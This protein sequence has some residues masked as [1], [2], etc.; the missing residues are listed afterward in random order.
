M[1][2]KCRRDLPAAAGSFAGILGVAGV[3]LI[4]EK[5]GSFNPIFQLTAAMYVV[6]ALVW[7][8]WCQGTVVFE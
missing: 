6:G 3:G 1:N 8:L 2:L 7:N 5:T 4:V